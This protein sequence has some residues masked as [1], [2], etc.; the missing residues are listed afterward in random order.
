MERVN[1]LSFVSHYNGNILIFY[2][3]YQNVVYSLAVL[4][5]VNFDAFPIHI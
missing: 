1:Y 5:L 4:E 2:S 3:I